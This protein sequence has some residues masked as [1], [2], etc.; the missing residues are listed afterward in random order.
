MMKW[1]GIEGD[2]RGTRR[3]K[4]RNCRNKVTRKHTACEFR[5]RNESFL[6]TDDAYK[7]NSQGL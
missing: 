5:N 1:R 3:E 2:A 7:E 6:R 4:K